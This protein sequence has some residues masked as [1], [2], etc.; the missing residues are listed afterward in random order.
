MV[1]LL[2]LMCNQWNCNSIRLAKYTKNL[3]NLR[4]FNVSLKVY[5]SV[6]EQSYISLVK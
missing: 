5:S 4:D 2:M 1:V 6:C 3:S